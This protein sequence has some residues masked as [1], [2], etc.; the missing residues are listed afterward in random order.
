M[1]YLE[2]IGAEV[3]L[4]H[5]Y[6]SELGL[7]EADYRAAAPEARFAPIEEV[8][9]QAVVLVLRYPGDEKVG[10]MRKGACLISM[11]HYPTRP[12]RVAFLK[13]CGIEA[14]SLDSL[15]DDTGRRLVENLRSVGWNG[16]ETAFEV[17]NRVYPQPGLEDPGRNPVKVTVMGAGA[18]GM[19][20][21]QAAMRYGNEA[22]WH[23]MAGEGVTGVQ[24]TAVEYDTTNH[25][26]I[27]QQILKY[28][29]LLVDATQRPDPSKPIIPNDWIR[30]MR[31][32]AVLLDLS[33]DP[34]ECTEE[35]LQIVKG[36]EGVP[37][38]SLDQF[39][40]APND[41]AF[42]NLPDCVD[43]THRRWS[44]SCYSWPGI[45]PRECME[46][47]GHQIA[48][49]FQAIIDCGGVANIRFEGD[50]FQRAISRALLSNVH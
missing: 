40:F 42:D 29:D 28:T 20:A 41:P 38:G 14:I 7:S 27:M 50:F 6:G 45:H 37:H 12:L 5:A 10:W 4:E 3:V 26:H 47:Y 39:V 46:L 24:V 21:I 36:I 19:F 17:L 32:S 44:V 8:Y 18:V 30:V 31:P 35:G 1:S 16:V 23:K 2:G 11:L 48:P 15:K 13:S 9:R 25:E 49:L 34:Y 22:V 43:T 33:V